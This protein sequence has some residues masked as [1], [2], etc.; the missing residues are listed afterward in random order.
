MT[1]IRLA[2]RRLAS[3]PFVT[4]VA[5]LSLA[6]GIGANA[7]IFSLFNQM[8]LRPLPV[9]A[10]HELVNLSAP[11]PKPGSQSCN[12]AGSCEEVFSYPMFRDLQR[13]Q[14]VF[15]DVA[16]HRLF[17]ANLS[18]NGQTLNGEG[19]LVSGSYF[20]VLRVQ[21]A[22]GRLLS[23]NDDQAIGES[24]VAV[25][26]HAYWMTRFGGAATVLNETLVV[27]GHHLTIV[28][29]APEGFDGTTLGARPQVYVPIT[30]RGL[31]NPG[32][33]QFDNRRTY[34]AYLFARLRDGVTLDQARAQLNVEYR[35]ILHEVEAPLQTGMSDQTLERFRAKELLV[36][37]GGRG[38]SSVDRE[39]RT[40]L[41]LLLAVT[42]LVLLIACANIANLLL[43]RGAARA[44]EM[45][46][47]LSIGANRRQLIGQL[48]TE[49]I[50]L[51]ICGGL[52]GLVVARWTLDVVLGMLPAEAADTL[53]FQLDGTVLLFAAA[54]TLATGLLFG[55]FPAWHTTRPDLLPTLKGQAGQ[56]GGGRSAQ[57]FRTTL[58]TTQI[59][60][61]MALLVCAG[62]FTKSL[63]NVS[64]VDLGIDIDNLVTFS[65]SPELNGYSPERS[66]ALFERLEDELLA[67]P[68]VTAVAA[69]LVPAIAGS[70]WGSSVSVE[71]FE[72]GPDTDTHSNYNEVGPDYFRTMGIQI[73]AGR[74]F[75][76]ADRLD[77]PKV[78]IVNEAFA[79]KFNLGRDAVGKRIGTGQG[80]GGGSAP[81]DIEIVG[82]A[83]DAKY[84]EVKGAVRPVFFRPYRQ[85]ERVGYINFY[86]RTSGPS[87]QLI[88]GLPRVVAGLDPDLPV[89]DLRTMPQQV[90]QNVFLD[91]IVST[92]SAGFATLATLL[93][94][95]GLYGVLAYTVAQR[96]REIG[97]RMA[98]GAAPG[99]V[100]LMILRQV[101]VMTA[102]GA[103]IGLAAALWAGRAAQALL[104]EMEGHDPVVLGLSVALLT[105]IALGAGFVPAHRASKID[106]M[107]ALRYE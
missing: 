73:L 35:A 61:S 34:W 79:R 33:T 78:A 37:E 22:L 62:L 4:L 71:G 2:V 38:Q 56:P 47:R 15:T 43:V 96:T 89:V 14:A 75:T 36:E 93:A 66:K 107:L 87:D 74:E 82:L 17:G 70:N 83:R 30:L 53:Q 67:Q 76:R 6:L 68:G 32:F 31:M 26:S 65:I 63:L 23:P 69:S 24:L 5:I 40:P 103:S 80:S 13:T 54:V 20:P 25:L 59:A 86:V 72:A 49:S 57:W 12:Q 9:P 91:R 55:L 10:P 16:A 104:Y 27:N 7:A 21:P 106:P 64:R 100:R 101:A 18:Y 98:L 44:S 105:V 1:S 88:R 94:A 85:N 19:V 8:L 52:A 42:G 28:G 77:S 50:V 41:V 3:T 95:I 84:S 45:A 51:A 81:L 102:I 99:R 29:V 46:I 90:R 58:A 92:L 97:L 11:G 60:I 48:L 39:A